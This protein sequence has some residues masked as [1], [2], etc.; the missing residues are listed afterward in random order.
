[1][2]E[3]ALGP[4]RG[5]AVEKLLSL[6]DE[7]ALETALA[8]ADPVTAV[9]AVAAAPTL[10]QKTTLLWAMED[11]R[12]REVLEALPPALVGALV[13]NLEEDNRYLLGDL[14]LE[15]F[16]ALLAL[17]SPERQYYW[18]TTALSF[19]DARANALPL[20]LTTRELVEI[21]L[22]RAEFEGHLRAIGDYPIEDARLPAE[23]MLDP[24]QTLVDLIGVENFLKEFP[25]SDPGMQQLLQTI[26][27]YDPDRYVD[28]IREGLRLAD[29]AENHPL[30]WETL[31]ED[32]VILDALEPLPEALNLPEFIP[33]PLL[34]AG[35]PLALV[36]VTSPPL[37]RLTSALALPLRQR[38]ADELQELF[39]RQAI[40]EGGSFLFS[41]LKRVARSVEAYL[42]LGLQAEG[43][44]SPEREAALLA[45]RSLH[46]ISHTGARVVESLRQLALRLRPLEGLLDAEGRALVRSLL[47]P[48]LTVG[49]DGSPRLILMPGGSLPEEIEIEP[50]HALLRETASWVTLARALGSERMEGALKR[51]GSARAL[52]EELV[53]G[54]VLY[55][56]LEP[57]LAEE[58]DRN[59]FA[60]RYLAGGELRPEAREGLRRAMERSPEPVDARG[61]GPLLE[62]SLDRLAQVLREP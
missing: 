50:A 61:V 53:L 2:S 42:L 25:L 38:V 45:G 22:T 30:E 27:D 39:I 5:T 35:P 12:R 62:G 4:E 26:L 33:A 58:E 46:K 6:D 60:A 19:T 44:G 31:T 3:V 11:R 23:L 1:M 16:R 28:L 54:A 36:P 49:P 41:D 32:P 10:E 29:Y 7:E 37:V 14:S 51:A 43:G 40:A 47:P 59:R 20:L 34:E 15:Q 8:A 55:A 24:A 18:V 13:Q 9:R 48:R 21:L 17:C 57:G 52:L 56:R